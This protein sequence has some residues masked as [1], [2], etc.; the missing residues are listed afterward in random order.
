LVGADGSVANV[1]L[2]QSTFTSELVNQCLLSVARQVTFPAS[3][4]SAQV[5]WTVRLRGT[6]AGAIAEASRYRGH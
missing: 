6:E 4:S 5:Y 2:G 1:T 3:A